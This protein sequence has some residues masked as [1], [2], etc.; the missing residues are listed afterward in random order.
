M[1]KG[2][3]KTN[4]SGQTGTAV[5][6]RPSGSSA[7]RLR[8][9]AEQSTPA[10]YSQLSAPSLIERRFAEELDRF[11]E[12]F[13]IGSDFLARG[14]FGLARGQ[15]LGSEAWAPAVEVFRR[16]DRLIIRA[17]LPG[18]AKDDIQIEVAND[19][20]AIQGERRQEHEERHE[21][22]FHSERSYGSFFRRVLLPDGVEA[23]KAEARFR[24]G[25]L[26]ITVPATRFEDRQRRRL[27]VTG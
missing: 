23:D 21:D 25:V 7:G 1:S 20:I 5:E 15:G 6:E 4:G 8:T 14:R 16:G 18:L 24:D 27:E 17:D 26:E 12:G 19:T 10:P 13:R 3:E 9:P 11:F 22:Y 2:K